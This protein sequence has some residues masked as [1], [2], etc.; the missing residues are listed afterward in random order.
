MVD[1]AEAAREAYPNGLNAAE[2]AR[3]PGVGTTLGMLNDLASSLQDATSVLEDK[4]AY[5]MAP[6]M[7]T[8][9]A[10][11]PGEAM[12]APTTS[13]LVADLNNLGRRLETVNRTI[14]RLNAGLEL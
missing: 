6:Q 5:L 3:K 10:K 14:R 13:G 2:P 4:L 8:A 9:G 12:P 11:S 1:I 7:D